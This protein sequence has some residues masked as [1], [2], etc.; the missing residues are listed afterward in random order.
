MD[1]IIL[2]FGYKKISSENSLGQII[3]NYDAGDQIDLKVLRDNKETIIPVILGE[4][5]SE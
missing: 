3:L 1:D 2:E 5:G 4:R